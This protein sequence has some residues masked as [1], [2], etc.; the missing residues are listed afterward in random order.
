M[1]P[2]FRNYMEDIKGHGEY[3]KLLLNTF[4]E[5]RAIKN[6]GALKQFLIK[7]KLELVEPIWNSNIFFQD[8][9]CFASVNNFSSHWVAN[10]GNDDART[11]DDGRW[12]HGRN[13]HGWHGWH[14]WHG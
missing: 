5:R 11:N 6:V 7:A 13:G 2:L 10:G 1:L 12:L 4:R 3:N 14:G 9:N 8:G